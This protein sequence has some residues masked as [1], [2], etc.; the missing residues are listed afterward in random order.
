LERDP[1][2]PQ[3]TNV[4]LVEVLDPARARIEI[5]ERGAGYTLA[6]GSSAA[7]VAAVLIHLRLTEPEVEVLMPGGSLRVRQLPSGSLLQAGPARRV[8]MAEVNPA[9]IDLTR[10]P[11]D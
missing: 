3:R 4:Q 7:A 2:F 5:W 9:E 8:F 1:R 10:R 11:R 6:S